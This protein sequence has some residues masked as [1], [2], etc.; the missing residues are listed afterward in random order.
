DRIKALPIHKFALGKSICTWLR[1]Y[2]QEVKIAGLIDLNECIRCIGT[3]RPEI[4]TNWLFAQPSTV[5]GSWKLCSE[6][7]I[8]RFG[9]S[10]EQEKRDLVRQLQQ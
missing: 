7:L 1:L 3:F 4:I 10:E 8:L 5:R 9:V 6:A 2:E